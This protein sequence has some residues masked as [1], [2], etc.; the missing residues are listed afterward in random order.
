MARE[1][2]AGQMNRRIQIQSQSGQDS[3]GQPS[4]SG[5]T[6]VYT[7]WA[8]LDVQNSQLVY[9]TS[10][11]VEKVTYRIAF[12]WTKSVVIMPNM[13]IVYTDPATGIVHTYNIEALVNPQMGNWFIVALCYELEGNQ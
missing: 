7:C 8:S 5:W 11:F 2:T 3:F 4:P 12:R 10:E 13:H 9:A 1:I 6:T